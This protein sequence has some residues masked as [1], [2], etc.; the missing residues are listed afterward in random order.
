MNNEKE[1]GA[2]NGVNSTLSDFDYHDFGFV[3]LCDIE[4]TSDNADASDEEADDVIM[5][6]LPETELPEEENPGE[7]VNEN[8]DEAEE[9]IKAPKRKKL[10]A[11]WIFY[12][13]FVVFLALVIGVGAAFFYGFIDAYENSLPAH[14]ADDFIAALDGEALTA[15]LNDTYD[16]VR[17]GYETGEALADICEASLSEGISYTECAS[18]YTDE[19][20]VYDVYCGGKMMRLYLSSYDS[21]RYGFLSYATEKTVVYEDWFDEYASSVDFIMPDG[22]S[23][24]IN[25]VVVGEECL[26][27]A[28]YDS[29]SGSI[30][31]NPDDYGLFLE[32]YF[33]SGIIGDATLLAE[34]NGYELE[35]TELGGEVYWSDYVF[36]TAEAFTVTAPEGAVVSING[37][38]LGDGYIKDETVCDATL[39]EFESEEDLPTFVEYEVSGLIFTPTVTASYEGEELTVI[40]S[41]DSQCVF[42]APDSMRKSYTV[43][44]PEGDTLYCNGTAVG[45]EYIT[46]ESHTYEF[47]DTASPYVSSGL[48]GVYYCVAGLY[49]EP[50]FTV[51]GGNEPTSSDDG[52]LLFYPSPSESAAS[53]LRDAAI[54]FTECFADYTYDG[55]EYVDENYERVLSL[56][57]EGSDAYSIIEL[58][59]V[60]IRYTNQYVIDKMEAEVTDIVAYS[61]KCWGVTVEYS[62][63]AVGTWYRDEYEKSAEGTYEMVYVL[64]GGEYKLASIIFSQ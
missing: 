33:I 53:D 41:T 13:S 37:V 55:Y 40:S 20:P 18:E 21:G 52:T 17:S 10:S 35:F 4:A 29:E 1:K 12:I 54:N 22:A 49:G 14:V 23:A 24:T 61:D 63:H 48:T 32:E 57:L 11:F 62:S 9:T 2:K 28:T 19:A 44:V 34:Y 5:F 7:T 36:D 56:T 58:T 8:S 47:P 38:E 42:D 30:F 31:E 26:T 27:G 16:A 39:S 3:D 51:S 59:Y 45:A 6:N 25:G 43:I 46:D 15:I 60:A 50:E 64:S